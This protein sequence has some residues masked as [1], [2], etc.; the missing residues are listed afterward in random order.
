MKEIL[1]IVR[2][3]RMFAQPLLQTIDRPATDPG[4]AL[5]ARPSSKNFVLGGLGVCRFCNSVEN[6]QA[7]RIGMVFPG[8]S[9]RLRFDANPWLV[10]RDSQ[11]ERMTHAAGSARECERVSSRWGS[12]VVPTTTTASTGASTDPRQHQQGKS[13]GRCE[14][15]ASSWQIRCIS[16]V[17]KERQQ[18]GRQEQQREEADE[19]QWRPDVRYRRGHHGRSR[20]CNRGCER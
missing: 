2:I 5:Y 17:R 13:K 11:I 16:D 10:H 6:D 1:D 15:Q 12:R 3:L 18:G 19:R 9:T 8:T 20:R 14:G 7:S 4:D